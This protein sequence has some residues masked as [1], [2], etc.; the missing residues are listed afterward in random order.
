MS[1]AGSGQ[2]FALHFQKGYVDQVKQ[3]A[4]IGARRQITNAAQ[5]GF[6]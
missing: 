3:D 1:F 2:N 6:N 5:F 4:F